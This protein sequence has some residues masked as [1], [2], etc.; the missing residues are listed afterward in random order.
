MTVGLKGAGHRGNKVCAG[1]P[2]GAQPNRRSW[3]KVHLEIKKGELP[4]PGG[5]FYSPTQHT[6]APFFLNANKN[7]FI[8]C[9][10]PSG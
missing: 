1:L 3:L 5:Q 9:H 6:L 7:V 10:I 8:Q 4:P 2:A